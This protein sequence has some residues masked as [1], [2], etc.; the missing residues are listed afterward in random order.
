MGEEPKYLNPRKGRTKTY[1]L[2]YVFNLGFNKIFRLD[3]VC[4]VNG[5]SELK[6]VFNSIYWKYL[7]FVNLRKNLER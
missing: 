7:L 2:I 5:N 6:I 4:E 1:N 3:I